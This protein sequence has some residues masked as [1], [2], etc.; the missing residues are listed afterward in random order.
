MMGNH[1][2]QELYSYKSNLIIKI[3]GPEKLVNE[4]MEYLDIKK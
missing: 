4:F 2:I 1:I 3:D